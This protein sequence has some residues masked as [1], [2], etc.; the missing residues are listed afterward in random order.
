[1][2][3]THEGTKV[4]IQ[5]QIFDCQNHGA[6]FSSSGEWDSLVAQQAADLTRWTLRVLEHERARTRARI[7]SVTRGRPISRRGGGTSLFV[8]ATSRSVPKE[9][10]SCVAMA[11]AVTF[12]RTEAWTACRSNI[13][14][15]LLS[16]PV[17]GISHPTAEA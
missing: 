10:P 6:R 7:A 13:P 3:C 9:T 16:P 4:N 12:A 2:A 11:R 17:I 1:M 5:G 8:I 14:S 15:I